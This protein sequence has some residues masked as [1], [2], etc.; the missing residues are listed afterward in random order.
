MIVVTG[1]DIVRDLVP[2]SPGLETPVPPG[3][4]GD[5]SSIEMPGCVCWGSENAPILKDASGKKK[6]YPF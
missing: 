3:G 6:L 1:H 4:G 5:D 2:L